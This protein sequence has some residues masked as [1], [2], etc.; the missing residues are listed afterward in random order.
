MLATIRARGGG[1]ARREDLQRTMIE[2]L[3]KLPGQKVILPALSVER[4]RRSE[5]EALAKGL[6]AL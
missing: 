3:A 6:G 2:R 4:M 1:V 5:V